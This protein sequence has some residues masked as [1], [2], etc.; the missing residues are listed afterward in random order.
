MDNDLQILMLEDTLSDAEL[1]EREL[2]KAGISFT[3]TRVETRPAFIQALETLHPDIILSDF[4]LPEFDG[5]SALEIV[6]RDFP[7]VP[8]IMVTG[9]LSDI[10]AVDLIHAGAKDY[11]L[12]DR[13]ARL[14]PA[15]R[16]TLSA[17]KGV[18]ARKA[19]EK[20]LRESEQRFRQALDHMLEGCM[21]ISYDWTYL[22][23]NEVAAQHGR[24][25]RDV[26]LNHTLLEMYPGIEQTEI[27]ARYRWVMEKRLPQR[28]ES[29]FTFP[30]GL[31]NWFEFSVQP[32]PE[33]IFVLS[34][35]IT[36]RKKAEMELQESEAHFRFVSE[37]AQA[38][39]WISDRDKL[40]TWFNKVWLD[41]TGRTLDEECGIGW[42][43]G[44]HPDDRQRCLETY[45]SHFD[46][47]EPFSMEYR[48]RR[49]DGEYRWVMDKGAPSTSPEGEFEGFIGSC[50][51][52]TERKQS[53]V[54]LVR[55]ARALQTLSACNETLIR[56]TSET[57]LL[58]SICRLIVQIGGYELAWVGFAEQDPEKT[59]RPVAQFGDETGYLSNMKI[60]WAD[61][62]LGRGPTGTAIRTG[63]IQL[64]QALLTNP[65]MA[66]WR[67]E[68]M[69]RHYQSSISLPLKIASGIIGALTIYAAEPDAFTEDEVKLLTELA[70]DL[71]FGIE[72]L[73]TR[74]ER[75]Q[76]ALQHHHHEVLLRQS[77]EH[78]IK[79]FVDTVELRDP[80]TA[81]HQRRVGQL[82]AAIAREM[83]LPVESIHGIELGASIHDL[84]KINV[85][86]E[87]LSK[88]TRLTKI[89]LML[90]QNHAQAG[91]DILKGIEFPW[92]IATMVWQ[93]HE[94]LD[95]SGYPRGLKG[96]EIILEARILS[97]ADVVE[98]MSSHRPYRPS[99]GIG[100]ALEEIQEN[101][102][103]FYD[104]K[105]VDACLS[106]FKRSDYALP[107]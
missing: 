57:R 90:I 58:E 106:L 11:V 33:G 104:E 5:L 99:R 97:V 24:Q 80:Y 55:Y 100:V 6:R 94:R 2:R 96:D 12:K 48:L 63:T 14:A 84:G 61:C 88:P 102:G 50:F 23:V 39:I 9:A 1:M 70:D 79:A 51:D 107:A 25:D 45:I 91:Y 49:H 103:I 35:D 98:A 37:S 85:P 65:A 62:E 76:I 66:P 34:H 92:P 60:Q 16:R 44:V 29:A 78:S 69:K 40:C 75:D 83:E 46:R 54:A 26:L 4:K 32:D 87:I 15:V 10:E 27:F 77:L 68:A 67:E 47:R 86:A 74:V 95:G 81:G 36:E 43:N 73:R 20:A 22:Y 72:T 105:V 28:F 31:T 89:E 64:N 42:S 71:A 21:L 56:A 18:R 101:R 17:E 30:D 93:H 82:A 41:F 59:V 13:L 3:T 7:Q 19:A 53:E 52:I 38:M 8:M